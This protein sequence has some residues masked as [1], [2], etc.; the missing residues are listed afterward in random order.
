[1]LLN[2]SD[3]EPRRTLHD[4]FRYN[5]ALRCLKTTKKASGRLPASYSKG[6]WMT[7]TGL[8]GPSPVP[9]S[10]GALRDLGVLL[11]LSSV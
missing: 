5:E 8:R 1:M 4:V 2:I 6:C 3:L 10:T 7:R 11:M 9:K